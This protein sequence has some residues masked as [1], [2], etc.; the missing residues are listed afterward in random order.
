MITFCFYVV[1]Q[2]L[3]LEKSWGRVN[4]NIKCVWVCVRMSLKFGR[5]RMWW[6]GEYTDPEHLENALN[7][8][9][10]LDNYNKNTYVVLKIN[11]A[12][13]MNFF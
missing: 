7:A 10:L 9:M 3:L 2:L 13:F 8:V 12:W 1:F 4:P 6:E 11:F 5:S